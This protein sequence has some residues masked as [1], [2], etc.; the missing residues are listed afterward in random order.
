LIGLTAQIVPQFFVQPHKSVHI[1]EKTGKIIRSGRK[2]TPDDGLF[3][4]E[5]MLGWP[6]SAP[7][8]IKRSNVRKIKKS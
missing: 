2:T 4:L 7:D 3:E 6:K 1:S 5:L 8:E